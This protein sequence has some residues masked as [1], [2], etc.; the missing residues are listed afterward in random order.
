MSGPTGLSAPEKSTFISVESAGEMHDACVE[1]FDKADVLIMAAAVA[2]YR[3]DTSAGK[4]PRAI[5][6]VACPNRDRLKSL[7]PITAVG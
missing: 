7:G 5:L 1:A 4:R 2:D 3:P 6:R